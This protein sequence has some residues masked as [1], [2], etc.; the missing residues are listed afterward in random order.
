MTSIDRPIVGYSEEMETNVRL[1]WLACPWLLQRNRFSCT[2][3]RLR[4]TAG[5]KTQQLALTARCIHE[6]K[7]SKRSPV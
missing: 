5:D 7:T 6:I 2:Y 3:R 1:R 4:T